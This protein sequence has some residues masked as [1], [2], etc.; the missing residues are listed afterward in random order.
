MCNWETDGCRILNGATLPCIKTQFFNIKTSSKHSFAYCCGEQ[1][2]HEGTGTTH[3]AD[4]DLNLRVV[5]G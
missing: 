5:H 2:S 4:L 3:T 1:V